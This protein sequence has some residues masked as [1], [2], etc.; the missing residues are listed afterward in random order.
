MKQTEKA[1]VY[2]LLKK[3]LPSVDWQRIENLAGTGVPD[4]NGCYNGTEFWIEN[5]VARSGSFEIRPDQVAWLTRRFNAGGKVFVLVREGQTL[6][7]YQPD[8][9]GGLTIIWADKMPI[10]YEHLLHTILHTD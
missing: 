6:S 3:N 8:G 7:M 2:T 4:V 10:D 1:N 5:K 9:R